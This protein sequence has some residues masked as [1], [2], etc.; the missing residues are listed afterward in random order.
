MVEPVTHAWGHCY[1]VVREPD[2]AAAAAVLALRRGGRSL[3][4]VLA[5]ARYQALLQSSPSE[6]SSPVGSLTSAEGDGTPDR[7]TA[8]WSGDAS[9]GQDPPLN[10]VLELAVA[11]ASTRPPVERAIVDLEHRVDRGGLARTL[12]LLPA[13]A[14]LRATAVSEIWARELDPA[15]LAW[16]GP[17]DCAELAEVL[18]RRTSPRPHLEPST[19]VAKPEILTGETGA[20]VTAAAPGPA[21]DV[22]PTPD[23]DPHTGSDPDLD[24]ATD[25]DPRTGSD[26]VPARSTGSDPAAGSDPTPGREPTPDLD[27]GT[28]HA[29]DQRPGEWAG[30]DSVLAERP[31]TLDSLL[32]AGVAVAAHVDTCEL[33]SDRR[34]SMVS[35]R[36]LQAQARIPPVPPAVRAAG[37]SGRF[38]LPGPLPPSVDDA[39]RGRPRR[40]RLTLGWAAAALTVATVASAAV[41]VAAHHARR[42]DADALAALPGAGN[43]LSV[44]PA[45]LTAG[46]SAALHNSSSHPLSWQ[47]TSGSSWLTVTPSAG[48]LSPGQN[49]QLS[50]EVTGSAPPGG[51]RSTVSVAGSD[52]SVAAAVVVGPTA[53]PI[54]LAASLDGCTVQ[55]QM[56]TE[57]S[58]TVTLHFRG[59]GAIEHT[60]VMTVSPPGS[61]YVADLPGARPLTWWVTAS[62]GVGAPTSTSTQTLPAGGCT[63]P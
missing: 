17:G 14:A 53:Q 3:S 58:A 18:Q 9:P 45:T 25:S 24:T 56:V 6:S 37:A 55:A 15:L 22:R 41:L 57:L 19:N 59:P 16:L 40:R 13:A 39:E 63:R 42:S 23:L 60:E 31:V 27:L 51:A 21:T 29:R 28:G 30:A 54:D 38:R 34:R 32:S 61:A 36:A 2:S 12:G 46:T 62:D 5:H 47:A 43:A 35:V 50:I 10:D 8:N 11:L 20:V 1:A 4:A 44:A 7:R 33:C 52:G 26:R 48:R 49:A